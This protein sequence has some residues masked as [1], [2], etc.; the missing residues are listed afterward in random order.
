MSAPY[1]EQVEA[2]ASDDDAEMEKAAL[3]AIREA[4]HRVGRA[5]NAQ[6]NWPERLPVTDDFVVLCTDYV[7]CWFDEDFEACVPENK[8]ATLMS[9]KYKPF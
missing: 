4:T 2:G 5:L 6:I 1:F 9:K 7:G 3:S 8:R